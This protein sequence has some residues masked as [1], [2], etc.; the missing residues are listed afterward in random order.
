M[1]PGTVKSS[2]TDAEFSDGFGFI[3]VTQFGRLAIPLHQ[4]K[5]PLS[6]R[7]FGITRCAPRGNGLFA[8]NLRAC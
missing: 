3:L 6:A 8:F 4:F 5:Q 7:F 1:T 2:I